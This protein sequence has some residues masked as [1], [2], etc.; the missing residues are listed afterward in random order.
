MPLKDR[1]KVTNLEIWGKLVKSWATGVNKVNKPTD[2]GYKIDK[3][4]VPANL[5]E[6]HAQCA[7]AGVGVDVPD[8]VL[9]LRVEQATTIATMVLR[10]P[11]KELV[12][13]SEEF[14]KEA[15]A[16]Y[17]IPDF[18]DDLY[19]RDTPAGTPSP[20]PD[21][22]NSEEARLT[23]HALRIGDYTMSNCL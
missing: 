14:L 12:E 13:N 6:F 18:Y 20:K 19:R 22:Q 21:I 17:G 10:L 8:Y 16:S 3:F 7:L 23:V 4:K 5:E 15:G 2:P 1:L 11:P 9:H